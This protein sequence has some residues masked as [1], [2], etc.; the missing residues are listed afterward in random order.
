MWEGSGSGAQ[1]SNM[2]SLVSPDDNVTLL[3]MLAMLLIT[4]IIYFMLT[5]YIE[6]VFPGQ[7]GTA[8]PFYFPCMP[9]YWCGSEVVDV[10]VNVNPVH[11]LSQD[12]PYIEPDPRGLERGVAINDLTKVYPPNN[13]AVNNLSLNMYNG[14]ITALLGHNGAGKTTTMSMLTGIFPPSSGFATVNGYDIR[15][16]MSE[17]R[18]SLGYCP[19]HD[20]L[21]DELTVKEHLKF[22]CTLKGWSGKMVTLET[23]RMIEA[24]GLKDKVNALSKTLSGGMKRKLSVGLALCAGSKVVMLDEPS[25]GMDPS[26]RRSTWDLLESEKKDRTVLL[27]THYM[28]EADVLGDRIAIMANGQLQCCGSSMFLKKKYGAGYHMVLIRSPLCDTEI[29][30][31][32][33]TD[34]VPN[35]ELESNMGAELSYIL[36]HESSEHFQNLFQEIEDR[37]EEL[38]INGYGASIT[39]MEEVFIKVG[40]SMEADETSHLLTSG[41]SRASLNT[42][43]TDDIMIPNYESFD[44]EKK[45]NR[46]MYLVMQQC[47]GLFVK[48]A[49][50]TLRYKLLT[51]SQFLLPIIM[52]IIALVIVKTMPKIDDKPALTLDLKP[53]KSSV[54]TGADL[55]P[56]SQETEQLLDKYKELFDGKDVFRR[57]NTTTEKGY[58]DYL[59]ASA[60]K[61]ISNFNLHWI[62]GM[63]VSDNATTNIPHLTATFNNQPYHAAPISLAAAHNAILRYFTGGNDYHLTVINHPLPRTADVKALQESSQGRD[64]YQL[65]QFIIMGICFLA[66]SFIVFLVKERSTKA[67][68][69]QVVSGVNLITFWLTTFVWDFINFIVPSIITVLMFVAFKT[70]GFDQPIMQGQLILLMV[71][72][73][74]AI[75]P[76]VYALSFFFDVAA[77]AYARVCLFMVLVGIATLLTVVILEIPQIGKEDLAK[78]LDWI[79]SLLPM[80]CLGRSVYELN[81]N[82][83]YNILCDKVFSSI[84][85][86]LP[87]V[88][89][90]D[91]HEICEAAHSLKLNLPCCPEYCTGSQCLKYTTNYLS[92]ESPG[93]GRLLVF[94][95]IDAIIFTC[96]IVMMEKKV[97]RRIKYA[98]CKVRSITPMKVDEMVVMSKDEDVEKERNRIL[99]QSLSELGNANVLV[100]RDLTKTY[101]ALN[102]VDHLSVG[103]LRSECFGL[104]GINGAGK[105]ST[106]KMITGDEAI[107]EGD[108][109]LDGYSVKTELAKVQQRL[110]YCPQFDALI[111]ELTGEET[112]MLFA[113]LRGVP[114]KYICQVV[115][116]LTED[117]L[118]EKHIKKLTKSYSGGNKRKLSVAIALIGEPPIVFLDEP[119]AGVDPVARRLMWKTICQVKD[120]GRSV[121]L[122]SHSME[123]CEALCERLVIMVN[124]TFCCLGSPQYLKM[125]FGDGYSVLVKIEMNEEAEHTTTGSLSRIRNSNTASMYMRCISRS[126]SHSTD[127]ILSFQNFFMETF[128]GAEMKGIHGSFIHFHV[129]N[130]E[131]VGW[132]KI[133]GTMETAKEKY[134]IEDYT[135]SQ[136]SLEQVFLQFAALQ[137][138]LDS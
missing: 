36:P 18:E 63:I 129:P 48:R 121:L 55:S 4:S 37:K 58:E 126:S 105:T 30:S 62:I 117:L 72:T 138:E 71:L 60:K 124:G 77:K 16:S 26:A 43:S 116:Q 47:L 33:I 19:Q 107:T 61:D 41:M 134:C 38:G 66:A 113:R 101:G 32:L 88:K 21:F 34:H 128:P 51:L 44:M 67:K 81:Q 122:T 98:I 136:T 6:A 24:M 87:F 35:A 95:V 54:I 114:E 25:S 135:V 108:A 17:I 112:L 120:S 132:A 3:H 90:Y 130:N 12:N 23:D 22:F 133:F 96:L 123:E 100:F 31:R 131:N 7:F 106:F 28:E 46:G 89:S 74:I 50:H 111:D 1:F 137:R 80:Y 8:K 13:V 99:N 93:I 110:G 5:W 68:H 115:N 15:Y 97:F 14:Q 92:W 29:V 91:D 39:T 104:L 75:L 86:M 27:T 42:T 94:L 56:S 109:Y 59:S 11:T 53:F 73:G 119:T 125:K 127:R 82:Y 49:M 83:Q 118:L 64:S 79:F 103:I 84:K 52:I 57:I 85:Q 69:L 65:A 40:E 20:V 10:R 76:M 9:S 78:T 2:A 102:A 45:R 70:D